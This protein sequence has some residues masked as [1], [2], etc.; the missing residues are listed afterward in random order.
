[1]RW[2]SALAA[3]AASVLPASVFA[4]D[5]ACFDAYE[6]A[7]RLRNNGKLVDARV[8]ALV[9]AADG[10]PEAIK[11]DCKQW[12]SEI[13]R[14]LA[15]VVFTAADSEGHALPATVVYVDDRKVADS[16]DGQ[17]V[18]VEPGAHQIRFESGDRKTEMIVRVTAGESGRHV[19]G[20][21]A[22]TPPPPP[23]I[24][25]SEPRKV[26]T[27]TFVLGGVAGVGLVSFVA[28]AAAG[29]VEQGCSP[30]CSSKQISTLR[31]EY[32]IADASWITG[33]AA[34]GGAVV[35]WL[36]RP[37][38]HAP[39]TSTPSVQLGT[40]PTPGGAVGTMRVVF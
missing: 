26:P 4:A 9:C 32:A 22:S 14:L 36:A 25:A 7:Q 16:I 19:D 33:L 31:T 27:A 6:Q 37:R 23:P 29:R 17:P 11:N 21:L 40:S 10:C 28:F 5:N 30:T 38:A 18:T 15:T 24:V 13:G 35:F 12:S 39:E 2:A 34:L 3:L 1:M 8:Q 20:V